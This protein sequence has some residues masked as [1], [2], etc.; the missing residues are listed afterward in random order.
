MSLVRGAK[1]S[2]SVTV[3]DVGGFLFSIKNTLGAK[4][5]LVRLYNGGAATI[6]VPTA[7]G[8]TRAAI[9]P[10]ATSFPLICIDATA[11]AGGGITNSGDGYYF[12]IAND[13]SVFALPDIAYPIVRVYGN[14]VGAD[15]GCAYEAWPL[16]DQQ[17][18]NIRSGQ[19]LGAE[20]ED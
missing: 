10:A 19:K 8:T 14:S 3:L 5:I 17:H 12:I 11:P 7:K 4:F 6:V 15:V 2:G 1:S 20:F 18:P 13:F 16:Y 9:E